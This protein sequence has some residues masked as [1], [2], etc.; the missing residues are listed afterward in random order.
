MEYL[1]SMCRT[2]VT[3]SSGSSR[4]HNFAPSHRIKVAVA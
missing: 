1:S 4:C 2:K 3:A